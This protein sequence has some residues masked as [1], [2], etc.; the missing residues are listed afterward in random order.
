VA[1]RHAVYQLD[2]ETQYPGTHVGTFL[3]EAWS[4]WLMLRRA[5]FMPASASLNS[6]SRSQVAGPMV[7]TSFVFRK[8]TTR[9]GRDFLRHQ[10]QSWSEARMCHRR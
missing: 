10:G 1:R 5:T 6:F 8:G 4:P 9:G 2:R 7:H 3:W